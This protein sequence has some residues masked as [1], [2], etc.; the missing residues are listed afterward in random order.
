MKLDLH[1]HTTY[2]DGQ[3]SPEQVVDLAVK[4][5]LDGIAI[6]D[7]DGIKGIYKAVKRSS[8]YNG[9]LVIPGIEF[10]CDYNG[11]EVHILGYYIDYKSDELAGILN[12]L[13]EER[14]KRGQKIIYELN[15]IGLEISIDDVKKYSNNGFI[16][17]PHIAQAIV[18]KEYAEDIKDAFN[19]YLIEGRPG[20]VKRYKLSIVKTIRLIRKLGG[21]AVLAHPGLL[22]DNKAISYSI[23]NG[24]DGIEAIHSKHS[25]SDTERFINI[26]KDNSLIA[27]GGSDFHGGKFSDD[28]SLG[29]Y[30]V[31]ISPIEM[32]KRRHKLDSI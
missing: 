29:K 12:M 28:N 19:R 24:I 20:Y 3:Y 11:E 7:H 31:D 23:D 32:L 5:K 14:I 2:S 1:V 26:A 16:G 25:S 6:T 15:K 17:R 13:N 8:I 22:K 21:V 18:E 9:F 27:T 10:S 30:Y 4:N